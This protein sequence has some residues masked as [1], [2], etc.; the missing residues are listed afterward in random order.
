MI[1]EELLERFSRYVKV[2]TKSDERSE[3]T[4]STACQLDLARI[5]KDECE[6]MGLTEVTLDDNGYVMATL[7]SN[8]KEEAPVI[9]FIAHMDTSPDF[10]GEGVNPQIVEYNGG[11]IYLNKD[12]NIYLSE[13]SYPVLKNLIGETIITTDGTTLL[14]ADDKNGIAE[15]MTAMSYLIKHPEIS[16][17]KIRIAFTPD[18]EVGRGADFFD[19]EKFGADFAY[20]IDGGALGELECENFNASSAIV[21]VN[22]SNIH[23]GYAKDKMKNSILIA[24]EFHNE[25]PQ[26]ESPQHTSGYEGF[27][28]LNDIEGSV[29]S[30]TLTY[31]LRDFETEGINNRKNKLKSIEEKLNSKYGDGTVEVILK[32]QYK[33]M[34]EV[35][36]KYP[37]VMERAKKAMEAL[38][39]V[40]E[41]VPIRG[42]TD[43]SRLSFMGLPCPNIFTGGYNFHGKYEFT[44]ISYMELAC[45]TIIEICKC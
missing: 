26:N 19:V 9:G 22:G 17:G 23:P 21:K 2:N 41:L 30:T 14:G 44:V 40:P 13:S 18:E 27:Y 6:K 36:D 20:T 1:R 29:E 25:L 15:I 35:I 45:K 37:E 8:I 33:N 31:I 38:D 28:H 39:I 16:H 24:Y 10:K 4:P 12:I 3:T 43:G 11:N 34:K 7:P 42:G 32:D 5:L